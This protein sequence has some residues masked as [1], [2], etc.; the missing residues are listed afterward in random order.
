MAQG[1]LGNQFPWLGNQ[2]PRAGAAAGR[3]GGRAPDRGPARGSREGARSPTPDPAGPGNPPLP[4]LQTRTGGRRSHAFTRC[5]Q[6]PRFPGS[7]PGAT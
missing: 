7:P 1:G 4:V 3:A 5:S 2:F 6:V